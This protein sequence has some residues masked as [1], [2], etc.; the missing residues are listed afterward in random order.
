MAEAVFAV[1]A[2]LMLVG[3]VGV[4][5]SRNPV[6]A[7]LFL[8]QTLVGVALLFLLHDAHFLAAV[9]VVVYAGAIVI[10]FLFVIM[11]LG[12]DK[13]EELRIEPIMGQRPLAAVVGAALAAVLGTV[14]FTGA[15]ALSGVV[16]TSGER[17]L[18]SDA[19][20]IERFGPGPVQ[21]VRLRCGDHGSP[22]DHR[23]RRSGRA[24]PSPR[25]RR[26]PPR[27]GRGG[28]MELAEISTGWYLLLSAAVFAI[29]AVGLLVRRNPLIMF[30]VRRADAQRGERDLRGAGREP[31][32]L[33]RPARGV[34]SC[35]WWRPPRW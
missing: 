32:R 31:Q 8:V 2:V 1:A 7:A 26:P 27:I 5:A 4:V 24:D 12:V 28:L 17:A 3:A 16:R 34:S 14:I 35:W 9:Q 13:A 18:D 25:R 6:H 15:D 22:A 11:L 10:L 21:R 30:M 33:G 29:G 23:S 20:D 19:T